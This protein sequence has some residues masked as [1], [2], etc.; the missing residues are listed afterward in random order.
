M[1]EALLFSKE[2]PTKTALAQGSAPPGPR[3]VAVWS[4]LEGLLAAGLPC[5]SWQHD[6]RLSVTNLIKLSENKADL[7]MKTGENLAGDSGGVA[8]N[9]GL[10]EVTLGENLSILRRRSY[11]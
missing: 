11:F 8:K 4:P 6:T 5:I 9:I 10:P 3:P 1:V 7:S 2:A